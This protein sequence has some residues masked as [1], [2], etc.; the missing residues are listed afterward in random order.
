MKSV[1]IMNSSL[2]GAYSFCNDDICLVPTGCK[3]ETIK[4]IK[5]E[6][7]VSIHSCLINDSFLIGSFCKGNENGLITSN[8]MES[9]KIEKITSKKTICLNSKLNAIGNNILINDTSCLVHPDFSDRA[10]KK[11]E[12][13]L[14][15]DV[16]RGTIGGIKTV[17]MAGFVTNK[18]L[19]VNSKIES[20]E[21]EKLER[22]FNIKPSICSVNKGSYMVGSAILFNTNGCLIGKDTTGYELGKIS[23]GLGLY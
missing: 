23:D 12:D 14:K 19:L 16:L 15:V 4:I 21:F 2:I 18:G 3:E 5:D 13:I 6:L 10:I 22:L 17:G 9:K 7:N 1:N 20:H 8:T 11:I